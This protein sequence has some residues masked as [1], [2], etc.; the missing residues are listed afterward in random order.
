MAKAAEIPK[1]KV[2]PGRRALY[3]RALAVLKR[4]SP[5]AKISGLIRD[6]LDR[7]CAQILQMSLSEFHAKVQTHR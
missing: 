6:S 1:T 5:D 4:S 3:D 7:R 2:E